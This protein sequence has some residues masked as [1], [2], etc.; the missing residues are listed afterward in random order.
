M[1]AGSISS[2][3]DEMSSGQ[4]YCQEATVISI[5]KDEIWAS[6]EVGFVLTSASCFSTLAFQRDSWSSIEFL[7][8]YDSLELVP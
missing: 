7:M 2:F 3:E 5:W 8:A 6:L 1:S 4:N